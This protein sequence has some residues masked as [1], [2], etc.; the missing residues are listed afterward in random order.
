MDN[1]NRI[2]AQQIS[3][4]VK[5]KTSQPQVAA[6]ATEPAAEHA[7]EP[8]AEQPEQP[9]E[10]KTFTK[11][12][13]AELKLMTEAE[14]FQFI[15]HDIRDNRLYTD[16]S[17]DRQKLAER[18][19]LSFAQIGA[20]FSRGSDY[21]SVADFIRECRLDYAC[22]L[23]TD[24]NMLVTEVARSAGFSRTTTFNHDFKTFYGLTP[25]EYRK[26]KALLAE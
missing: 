7:T 18:Y 3:E 20:A 15:C 21:D 2:L 5:L 9:Q 23:L 19:G 16:L 8:A 17:C 6:Q 22:R 1:K 4:L 25:S 10:E 13:V 12:S 26:Q 24:T 11:T 14:L